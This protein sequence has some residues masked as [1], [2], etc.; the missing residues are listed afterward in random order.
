MLRLQADSGLAAAG[1]TRVTGGN[2]TWIWDVAIVAILALGVAFAL[3][4][5]V[6]AADQGTD[7]M[8]TIAGAVQEGAGAYLRRQFRTLGNFAVIVFCL[9]LMLPAD[10]GSQ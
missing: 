7:N 2:Y 3:V 6:L 10:S 9:L 1:V 4:R 8:R 5:G